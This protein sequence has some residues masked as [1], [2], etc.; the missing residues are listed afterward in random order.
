MSNEGMHA[1][2]Y[3]GRSRSYDNHRCDRCE[4]EIVTAIGTKPWEHKG[5]HGSKT[6]REEAT[7]ARADGM[8]R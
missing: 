2:R 3:L 5:C 8:S 4:Y 7:K 1:W 6:A